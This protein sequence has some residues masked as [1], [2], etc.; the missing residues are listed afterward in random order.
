MCVELTDFFIPPILH[1]EFMNFSVV[2]DSQFDFFF[3]Q[4]FVHMQT[5][6]RRK[7]D[8]LAMFGEVIFQTSNCL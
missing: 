3:F 8:G 2:L 6:K 4:S 5:L 7:R 1:S